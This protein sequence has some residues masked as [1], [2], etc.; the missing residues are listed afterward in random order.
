MHW[1]VLKWFGRE[2]HRSGKRLT[3][4]VCK[5]TVEGTR[6]R[7]KFRTRWLIKVKRAYNVRFL[8]RRAAKEKCMDESNDRSLW[9]VE[10]SL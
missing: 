3:K 10:V 6:G 5:S 1:K 4:S 8:E 2:E 9:M 7:D